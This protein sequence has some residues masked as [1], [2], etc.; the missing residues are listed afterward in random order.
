MDKQTAAQQ[1]NARELLIFVFLKVTWATIVLA[2]ED[3]FAY[4]QS[5]DFKR[6]AVRQMRNFVAIQVILFVLMGCA[7]DQFSAPSIELEIRL[8]EYLSTKAPG[9]IYIWVSS[10]HGEAPGHQMMITFVEWG[11]RHVQDMNMLLK[12]WPEATRG[13]T[14]DLLQCAATDSGQVIRFKIPEVAQQMR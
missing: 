7:T 12:Q 1:I 14:Y 2:I 11:N 5:R 6:W 13:R 3:I 4:P 8:S 9:R 10:Y